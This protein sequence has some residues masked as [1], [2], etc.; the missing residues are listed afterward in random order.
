MRRGLTG[1][2]LLGIALAFEAPVLAQHAGSVGSAG[3]FGGGVH[4]GGSISAPA[5]GF[6]PAAP[7]FSAS[8][9]APHWPSW[10]MGPSQRWPLNQNRGV[11]YRTRSPY[12]Y[13]GYPWLSFGYGLPLAYGGD[14][15]DTGGYAAVPQP[16]PDPSQGEYGPEPEVAGNAAPT[17]RPPYQGQAEAAPVHAQP[18]TTLIFKDGRPPVQVYNYALT[19]TT[20]YALDGETRQEI[21]LAMLNVPATVQAN[22]A[23]GVDFALPE[24][25]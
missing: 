12:L 6:V 8:N 20:L 9:P 16:E 14:A 13:A 5:R 23:S 7:R 4:A 21:P 19:G 3:H 24:S 18:A 2:V 17:F 25:R 10:Q 11:G 15:D 1:L 22:R